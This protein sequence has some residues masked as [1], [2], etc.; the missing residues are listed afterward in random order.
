MPK[1]VSWDGHDI[2]DGTDYISVLP[3]LPLFP[4][5][6]IV[7]VERGDALPILAGSFMNAFSFVLAIAIENNASKQA[8]LTQLA[9]WFNPRDRQSKQLIV[10]DDDGTNPRYLMARC[11]SLVPQ[12][13]TNRAYWQATLVVDGLGDVD[14]RFLSTTDT[15]NTWLITATGQTKVINNAGDDD[16]YPVLTIKPTSAKSDGYTKKRFIIVTWNSDLSATKYPVNL[17]G[18]SGFDTSAEVSGGD[19]QAD[20]DDLRIIVDG[21]ETDRWLSGMNTSATKIWANLDFEAKEEFSIVNA[22]GSGDTVTELAVN[23]N[24]VAMPPGGILLI[25]SE[26]FV[27]SSKNNATRIFSGVSRAQK[28]TSAGNHSQGA[29]AQWIQHDIWM[30]YDNATTLGPM[31]DP[32]DEPVFELDT[33]DNET[34]IYTAFGEDGVSRP[35][36]WTQ[37]NQA[38]YSGDL[39][40]LYTGDA[41]ASADPWTGI[42]A[43]IT[44][45]EPAIKSRYYSYYNPCG[46]LSVQFVGDVKIVN[47]SYG[48]TA[49]A[50]FELYYYVKAENSAGTLTTIPFSTTPTSYGV[51]QAWDTNVESVPAGTTKLRFGLDTLNYVGNITEHFEA[52]DVTI[53]LITTQVP[54]AT[55]GS[56]QENYPLGATIT[57]NTTG[58]AITLSVNM[59]LNES[60]E[61]DTNSKTVIYLLDGSS[62]LQALTLEGSVRRDWLRLVPGDNTLQ[63]D[64]FGTGNVTLT[65]LHT[66]RWF[67]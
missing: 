21:N 35:G 52:E 31:V 5:Y 32:A 60:L 26:L 1:I 58:E 36:G 47:I 14:G 37:V 61:L 50:A 53:N 3:A 9:Q 29:T 24:I 23:E 62:Q 45:T 8:L 42:G 20:G 56:E 65:T 38:Q 43:F 19:M 40:Y 55:I 30:L 28:G 59:T 27:Y 18:N 54:I 33:S 4:K 48:G 17:A 46:L 22:I 10:A 64:D 13:K 34:H 51:T 63:F 6:E 39:Y 57:N 12:P 11:A 66:M 15:G 41:G 16:T 25:G 67:S 49:F 44:A 2:N 7:E